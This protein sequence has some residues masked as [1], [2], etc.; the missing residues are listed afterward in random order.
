MGARAPSTTPHASV[1]AQTG[2]QTTATHCELPRG[3]KFTRKSQNHLRIRFA[4]PPTARA[5]REAERP[6]AWRVCMRHAD[7]L[8]LGPEASI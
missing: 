5:A 6:R 1:C 8:W 2:R 4:I 3:P 7:E